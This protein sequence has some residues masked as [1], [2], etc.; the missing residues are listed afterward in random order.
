MSPKQDLKGFLHIELLLGLLVWLMITPVLGKWLTHTWHHLST[1]ENRIDQ[2]Q[3]WLFIATHVLS[4]FSHLHVLESTSLCKV[5][6]SDS[7]PL[8]LLY[9]QHSLSIRRGAASPYRLNDALRITKA[10]CI[11]NNAL[12]TLVCD[13]SLGHKELTWVV[14]YD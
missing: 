7:T 1:L 6:G 9:T 11:Q 13:T 2:E 5:I 10:T 3:E 8:E 14:G 4:E 12:V